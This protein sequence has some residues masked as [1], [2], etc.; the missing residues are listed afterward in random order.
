MGAELEP[1]SYLMFADDTLLLGKESI[2]E[3]QSIMR[4][5]KLYETWSGQLVSIQKSTVLFSP[6]V[7][8]QT[9][10]EIS[11]IL[12]T[13]E[14]ST[15]G[16]YLGL[17]TLIGAPQKEVFKSIIDRINTK[18]ANWN[19]RLLLKE[20]SEF[21]MVK[22]TLGKRPRKRR[23]KMDIRDLMVSDLIDDI[24]EVWKVD[25]V[26]SIFYPV[27]SE[28]ILQMPLQHLKREDILVLSYSPKGAFTV[29]GAYQVQRLMQSEANSTSSS[30]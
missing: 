22:P 15:H 8:S 27:D 7:D 1:L 25:K 10:D 3:A 12:G 17:P 24:I 30:S 11:G 18:V 21:R 2:T 6:N 5:L 13:A 16:K 20:G 4:I 26:R 19:P 29:K 23:H 14:V 9:R 28:A